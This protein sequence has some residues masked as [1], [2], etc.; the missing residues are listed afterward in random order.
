MPTVPTIPA[1]VKAK[2]GRLSVQGL[3]DFRTIPRPA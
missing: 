3:L 2:A 1:T